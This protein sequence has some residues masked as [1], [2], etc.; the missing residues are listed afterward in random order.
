MKEERNEEWKEEWVREG[1]E[2]KEGGRAG[3]NGRESNGGREREGKAGSV[4]ILPGFASRGEHY[5]RCGG[6]DTRAQ[7]CHKGVTRGTQ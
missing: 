2:E 6:E 3:R 4:G 5:R 7:W 1:R